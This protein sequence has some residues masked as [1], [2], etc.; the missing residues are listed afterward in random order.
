MTLDEAIVAV[1][2]TKSFTENEVFFGEDAV[3]L[4][5]LYYKT[6]HADEDAGQ[7]DIQTLARLRKQQVQD[8]QETN[9]A[10]VAVAAT[11]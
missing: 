1:K 3:A 7:S 11:A 5:E 2:E 4:L 9:D 10:E 6:K 8:A